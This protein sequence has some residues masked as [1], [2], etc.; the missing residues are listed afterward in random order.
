[1][2][3]CSDAGEEGQVRIGISGHVRHR[4][5]HLKPPD[6]RRDILC[7][8]ASRPSK[9][10][11]WTRRGS[12]ARGM[13]PVPTGYPQ[14]L[15]TQRREAHG[16]M[17][18]RQRNTGGADMLPRLHLARKRASVVLPAS[19]DK[20]AVLLLLARNEWVGV[21]SLLTMLLSHGLSC[22]RRAKCHHISEMLEVFSPGARGHS[23]SH[24]SLPR[25][26]L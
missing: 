20:A 21:S 14:S 3:T 22:R 10:L 1:M 6:L 8:P 25:P 26:G 2:T 24:L 13:E 7:L 11:R 4:R 5:K 17:E 16:K 19:P 18:T 15:S 9:M 12:S 23:T